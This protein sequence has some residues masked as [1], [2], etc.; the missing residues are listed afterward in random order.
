MPIK[1]IAIDIDG[2]LINDHLEIT[3]KTKATLQEATAKGIK[4]V[5]CTGRPM[6]G[7]HQYLDQLGLNNRDDQYVISFNG[8]LAQTTSG[9]VISQFTLPF[10][11]MVDLSAAALKANIHI[12]AETANTMY[13]LNQNISP[14]AVRESNLVSLP[15]FYRSIDQLAM[16]RDQLVVS[17]LM[18]IDDPTILDNFLSKATAPLKRSFNIVRSEPYYLEFVN[19]SASK[20]AALAS[21]GQKLG[22]PQTEIMAIGNA[23]NDESMITY[24]GVGVAMGNSIPSTLQQADELVADNNHDG[25]AEA[26]T[27]F[28]FN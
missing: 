6:T 26:V 14:Y 5:L 20:G 21:L 12:L 15:I 23:Q 1:L 17:K 16:I 4:V 8:A 10:E 9:M 2:T 28:A 22:I 13:V 27:K 7:V 19:P 11:K 18:L 25:V 24:A 3:E